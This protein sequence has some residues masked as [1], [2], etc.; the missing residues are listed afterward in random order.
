MRFIGF[1]AALALGLPVATAIDNAEKTSN[2]FLQACSDDG[3]WKIGRKKDCSWVSIKPSDRCGNVGDDGRTAQEACPLACDSCL[4]ESP[5]A[6]PSS[7][8]SSEPTS[9]PSENPSYTPSEGPTYSKSEGPSSLPSEEPSFEPSPT[10][11]SIPSTYPSDEPSSTPSD[12]PSSSPPSHHPSASPSDKPSAVPSQL[13]SATPSIEP[14][15]V[16]SS[17]PSEEP[18]G[19][20]PTISNFFLH[21]PFIE[22][23]SSEVITIPDPLEPDLAAPQTDCPHLQA[24]LLDWHNTSTWSMSGIPT[25]TA[26]SDVTLPDNAKV[27]I[28]SAVS[29]ALGTVLIPSTSELILGPGIQITASGFEVHGSL[30]AGSETCRIEEKVDIV[31]TGSRPADIQTNPR[32]KSYKG[33]D[34]DGGRLELHGKRYFSTWSRLAKTVELGDS[35]ILLQHSVNWEP[36]QQIVLVTTAMKDSREFHQNEIMTVD[37]LQPP[38]DGVGAVVHLKESANYTHTANDAYQGEVGLL[39]RMISVS[40]AADDSEASDPDPLTCNEGQSRFGSKAQPCPDKELTGYGGHI[41]VHNGGVGYVEGVELLRMGQT[42]VLGRYPMHF[43]LL[44]DN[45]PGCYLRDSSIHHS[46]YRCISVHA[47][48]NVTVSENVAFDV[49][50]Y[51]YYLEDG[52]EVSSNVPDRVPF[53]EWSSPSLVV[54]LGG[55]YFVIQSRGLDPRYWYCS[56][57]GRPKYGPKA[58]KSRLASSSRRNSQWLLHYKHSQQYHWQCRLGWMEWFCISIARYASRPKQT[59]GSQADLENRSNDRWQHCS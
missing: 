45:C 58:S 27:V 55:Q 59:C 2:R 16:P 12:N 7:G 33:I 1:F 39:S 25:P 53:M 37:Y 38:P 10:P 52:I 56:G 11:S 46:F 18:F 13:P 19:S 57:R 36:G 26:G 35:Y 28:R 4:L 40:G 20:P 23:G 8:P 14:S 24:G 51:C 17:F 22:K 44:G 49:I 29:E 3:N 48:N 30:W 47:T 54:L 42:N 15:D 41:I 9:S 31:L 34:V 50:G 21:G 5:S 32:S 6:S 43:H